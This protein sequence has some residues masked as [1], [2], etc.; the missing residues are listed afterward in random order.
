[1]AKPRLDDPDLSL[2]EVMT[3]WPETVPVFLRHRMLCVGCLIGPFHTIDDA[4]TE[5]HLDQES[6][7]S[8]LFSA[9]S[10]NG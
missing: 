4:C 3:Y 6:F 8:E 1:M 10:G 9:V 2:A 5:Y 7:L